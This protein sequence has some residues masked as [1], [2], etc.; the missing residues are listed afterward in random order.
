MSEAQSWKVII[1]F[2]VRTCWAPISLSPGKQISVRFFP[3]SE[4]LLCGQKPS[5]ALVQDYSEQRIC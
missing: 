1:A 2:S 3:H 5:K 4:Y